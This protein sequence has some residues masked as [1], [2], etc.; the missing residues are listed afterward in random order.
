MR[1]APV[2]GRI[3]HPPS[4]RNDASS[5]LARGSKVLSPRSLADRHLS[6]EQVHVCSNHTEEAN[7]FP[8]VHVDRDLSF[9]CSAP[10][11]ESQQGVRSAEANV[12]S[13]QSAVLLHF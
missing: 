5:N 12:E 3:R 4:K 10:E 13:T 1:R 6:T 8:P 11:F 9:R 2:S 7:Q